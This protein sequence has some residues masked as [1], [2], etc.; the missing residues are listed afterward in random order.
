M[1]NMKSAQSQHQQKI[2]Q[3]S[4]HPPFLGTH[5]QAH[6]HWHTLKLIGKVPASGWKR[7]K[8]PINVVAPK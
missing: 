2:E 8:K 7:M 4:F 3:G 5:T 1:K 6:A